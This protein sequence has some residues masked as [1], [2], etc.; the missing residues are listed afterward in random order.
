MSEIMPVDVVFCTLE[1]SVKQVFDL[2]IA[3][4]IRHLPVLDGDR[5][6]GVISLRH[7]VGNWLGGSTGDTGADDLSEQPP[8]DPFEAPQIARLPYLGVRYAKELV[9]MYNQENRTAENYKAELDRVMEIIRTD[10]SA[11]GIRALLDRR[12]PRWAE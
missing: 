1:T 3:N 10:D 8:L 7:V 5:L 9:Q 2:T 11:E 6:S 12:L 4:G